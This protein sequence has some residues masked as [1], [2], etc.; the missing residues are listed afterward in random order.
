MENPNNTPEEELNPQGKVGEGSQPE[1]T[2]QTTLPSGASGEKENLESLKKDLDETKKQ[3]EEVNKKYSGSSDEARRFKQE[4]EEL[5][6]KIESIEKEEE[7][8]EYSGP[9]KPEED[10]S[11]KTPQ[12]ILTEVEKRATAKALEQ[13]EKR[14]KERAEDKKRAKGLIDSASGKYPLLKTSKSYKRM[15]A[16]VMDGAGVPIEEACERVN[17]FMEKVKAG[18]EK[19]PFVEGAKGSA[20]TTPTETEAE[21]IKRSLETSQSTSELRGL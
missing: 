1:G 6:E 20:S 16:D 4:M 15:V 5:R 17:G 21:K 18:K 11:Q 7:E 12:E 3:L 19:E 2:G 13:V 9:E 10:Y 14:E 8:E